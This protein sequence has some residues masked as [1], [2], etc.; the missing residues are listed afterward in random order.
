[1]SNF[2]QWNPSSANQETDSQYSADTL[3]QGGAANPSLFPSATAN[4]LFYQLSTFIAGF[5]NALTAKGFTVTD[6]SLSALG[7]V[8]ANVMTTADMAPYAPLASPA[9]TGAPTA[10]TP[11]AGDSS[12]KLATTGF[13][14]EQNYQ[15]AIGFQPVQQG[16]GAFQNANKVYL[17]WD[18]SAPRIQIDTTDEGE[19][20]MQNWVNTNFSTTPAMQSYVQSWVE[21]WVESWVAGQGFAPLADFGSAV[22][23][24]AGNGSIHL[25][26]G[27][28]IQFGTGGVG[29]GTVITMPVPFASIYSVVATNI[30]PG[31]GAMDCR[32]LGV[33]YLNTSQFKVWA[34][35]Q[36]GAAS[37]TNISWFAM[38]F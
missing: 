34:Y 23:G 35:D 5:A 26:N 33:A 38:G 17:G 37:S 22:S 19:V 20:A 14:K 4:K 36:T 15:T 7:A 32:T 16:G 8:L 10:P 24:T 27:C 13:V 30:G 29:T 9:L 1:M 12:T 2:L 25:P 3:R 31:G 11:A 18:G 6:T 21:A 28:I